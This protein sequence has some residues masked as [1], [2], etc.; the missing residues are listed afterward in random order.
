M[1][2][3]AGSGLFYCHEQARK[4]SRF[5]SR[6]DNNEKRPDQSFFWNK[7]FEDTF[8]F[9]VIF[10]KNKSENNRT[11]KKRAKK[12]L[13]IKKSIERSRVR[14]PRGQQ[15]WSQGKNNTELAY[16]QLKSSLVWS[17]I[18]RPT[19]WTTEFERLK[20]P[21]LLGADTGEKSLSQYQSFYPFVY[22][23]KQRRQKV[24]HKRTPANQTAE[25]CR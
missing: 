7:G 6:P 3:A 18:V 1:N 11:L 14:I 15:A 23:D 25:P 5:E 4:E 8:W 2:R 24:I 22:L 20:S 16:L 17:G 21:I 13:W 10:F 9:S 19:F 12:T